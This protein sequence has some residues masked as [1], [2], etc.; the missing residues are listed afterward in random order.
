MTSFRGRGHNFPARRL[1][2]L[3]GGIEQ[4]TLSE[5]PSRAEKGHVRALRHCQSPRNLAAAFIVSTR[6]S[7]G[8]DGKDFG[9]ANFIK[10]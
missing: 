8:E 6:Q 7:F 9:I 1:K 3:Q 2:V 5:Q 4:F 10:E